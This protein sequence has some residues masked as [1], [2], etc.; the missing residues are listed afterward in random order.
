MPEAESFQVS[1]M[2]GRQSVVLN[3][4]DAEEATTEVVASFF[5]P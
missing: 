4:I 3:L 2:D 1:W 5:L